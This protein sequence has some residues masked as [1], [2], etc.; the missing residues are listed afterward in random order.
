MQAGILSSREWIFR[1]SFRQ[2]TEYRGSRFSR[3]LENSQD[4]F[5]EAWKMVEFFIGGQPF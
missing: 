3:P 2:R 1:E 4:D 5:P